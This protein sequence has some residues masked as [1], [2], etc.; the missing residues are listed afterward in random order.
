MTFLPDPSD[1]PPDEELTPVELHDRFEQNTNLDPRLVDD[2]K[3]SEAFETYRSEKQGG[4]P[5]EQPLDDYE[6]LARTPAA[7]WEDIDDGFNEVEQ[8][9]ELLDYLE[10]TAAQGAQGKELGETGVSKQEMSLLTWGVDPFPEDEF[11]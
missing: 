1:D 2:L 7:E 11:P 9:R 3:E 8:A 6:R 10:R 5:V 4:Q